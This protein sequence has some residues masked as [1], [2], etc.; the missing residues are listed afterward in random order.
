MSIA[1]FVSPGVYQFNYTM[2]ANA[3]CTFPVFYCTT[4]GAG[5]SA[6]AASNPAPEPDTAATAGDESPFPTQ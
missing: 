2:P 5:N 1:T 6:A 4:P 3:V